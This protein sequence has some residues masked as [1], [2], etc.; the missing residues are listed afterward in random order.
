MLT[1]GKNQDLLNKW[2]EGK[3]YT[4]I[5]CCQEEIFVNGQATFPLEARSGAFNKMLRWFFMKISYD[6]FYRTAVS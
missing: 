1:Q 6:T 4:Q 3:K 5:K 2:K